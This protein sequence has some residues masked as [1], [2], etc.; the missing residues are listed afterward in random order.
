MHSIRDAAKA[1]GCSEP[2]ARKWIRIMNLGKKVGWAVILTDEDV[3]TLK[4]KFTHG[5]TQE[6]A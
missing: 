1:I 2:W 3:L 6:V 5:R 4:E